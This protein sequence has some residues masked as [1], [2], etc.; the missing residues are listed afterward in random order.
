MSEPA[1][2]EVNDHEATQLAVKEKQIDAIPFIADPQPALARDKGEVATEF[3][4][5][6]F[7]MPDQSVLQIGLRILVFQPEKFEHEGVFDFLVGTHGVSGLR[8]ARFAQHRG[9]VPRQRGALVELTGNL[10]I[11]LP[12]RPTA[13]QRLCFVELS[14]FFA[15]ESQQANVVRPRQ[16]K[17]SGNSPQVGERGFVPRF[18]RQRREF[19]QNEFSRHCRENLGG[20]Q[21]ELP[22][23]VKILEREAAP[24]FPGEIG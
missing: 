8:L 16:W 6:T 1:E 2:L 11:K 12:H 9:L 17:P 3:D 19:F 13:A 10:A 14:G 4:E 18:S 20:G 5:K 7:Q 15:A 22:V 23:F 24:E 21:K